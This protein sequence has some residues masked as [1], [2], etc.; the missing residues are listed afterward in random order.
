M[1][2][3]FVILAPFL[4]L[5]VIGLLRFIGCYDFS[6]F[7]IASV[8]ISP[9]TADLGPGETAQF[10]IQT[11]VD[12]N[13]VMPDTGTVTWSPNAPKGLYTA[14]TPFLAN[15]DTVTVTFQTMVEGHS[16]MGTDTANIVLHKVTV[17]VTPNVATLKPGEPQPFTA[18]VIGDMN[19]AVKWSGNAPNGSYIAPTPYVVGAPPVIVTATSQADLSAQGTAIITLIGNGALFVKQDAL[20][21]GTW[22]SVAGN[23]YGKSGYAI[24]GTPNLI[25]APPYLPDLNTPIG[26]P[27]PAG[28]QKEQ[29]YALA[30]DARD[31]VDPNN[32]ANKL[33]AVW[34]T[35]PAFA[36]FRLNFD[37][38]DYAV[39]QISVYSAAW[40]G[41]A[42][43]Q[44]IR[45]LDGDNPG[46]TLDARN[47]M[48]FAKGV[49]LVWKVTGHVIL[50]VANDTGTLNASPNAVISGIFF[51]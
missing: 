22:K 42:R 4:L 34:Y 51:D 32:L 2:D 33:A 15:Q 43:A 25:Q 14:P 28:S 45:V 9:K 12:N 7:H 23:V 17:I 31:I 18:Q 50:E 1:P 36:S 21:Q 35:A 37:F 26:T 16:F 5:G 20:T 6:I 24:A 13:P 27:S 49:Y 29:N 44:I 11:M 39:H 38:M 3:T 30:G 10:S 47:L 41:Q 48:N 46:T 40:D 8:T 19:T